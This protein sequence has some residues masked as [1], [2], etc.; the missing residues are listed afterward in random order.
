M[1]NEFVFVKPCQNKKPTFSSMAI[2]WK[3]LKTG[4]YYISRDLPE[5]TDPLTAQS[6]TS[7]LINPKKVSL[8]DFTL[9]YVEYLGYE[10]KL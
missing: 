9:G 3:E 5:K 6:Y 8:I 7:H 1:K 4:N 10:W 2:L